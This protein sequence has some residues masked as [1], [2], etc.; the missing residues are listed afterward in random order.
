ME[1]IH[2]EFGVMAKDH[3]MTWTMHLEDFGDSIHYKINDNRTNLANILV[4][5][6]T[7]GTASGM[8]S[9]GMSKC[10]QRLLNEIKIPGSVR[11]QL[12]LTHGRNQ[13]KFEIPQQT[14]EAIN[15]LVNRINPYSFDSSHRIICGDKVICQIPDSDVDV[16]KE[17]TTRSSAIREHLKDLVQ[18]KDNLLLVDA[19]TAFFLADSRKQ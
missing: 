18:P 8:I 13:S 7:T 5:N 6:L 15:E 16:F 2:L 9:D 1:T 19:M 11:V 4:V 10:I 17:S 14:T 3:A 12:W